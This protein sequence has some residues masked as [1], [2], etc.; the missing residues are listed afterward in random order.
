MFRE[1][2]T[3]LQIGLLDTAQ[4]L[5]REVRRRLKASWT[6]TFYLGVFC[7]IDE[8]AFGWSDEELVDQIQFNLQVRYAL[9]L[10]DIGPVPFE[11]RTLYNHRQRVSRHMQETGR[12]LLEGVFVQ[13]TDQQVAALKVK[14]GLNAWTWCWYR[15]TCAR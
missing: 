15:A 7:R 6:D 3:H 13:V 12:N 1:N 10:R 2:G 5:P 9:D 8:S 4:R 11:L 14:T